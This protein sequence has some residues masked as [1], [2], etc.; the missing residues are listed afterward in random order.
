MFIVFE[1]VDGSGKDTQLLKVLEYLK[2][3]NKNL[4][5]F[6]TKEPTGN[7]KSGKEILQKLKSTGFSSAKE[8][9]DLYVKDREEQS[10]LRKEILKHS[11]ILSTRFDYSTYAYQG[12][13]GLSFDEIYS[14]HNYK[15]ILIPDITF[16][17]DVSKENIENRL[18]KRGGEKETFEEIDFLLKVREK[19]LETFENLKDKRTIYLIDANKSIE[20]TF[21]QIKNILDN[22]NF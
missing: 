22:Y 4:Q 15:N 5:F 17:F 12:A 21:L 18:K 20:E 6:L 8:A 14:S 1:G 7:T 19:Y 11:I 10:V 2:Q 16:L 13:S 9:L 3:R